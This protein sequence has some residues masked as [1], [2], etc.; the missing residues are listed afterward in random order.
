[1]KYIT[2]LFALLFIVSLTSCNQKET[3][4]ETNNLKL[5]YN[6]PATDWQSEALPIGNGFIGT[7]FFG[8]IEKEQIQFSEGTLW[9]GGLG[10]GDGYNYGIKK[11][12]WKNLAEVRKLLDEGKMKEAH[13]LANKELTGVNIKHENSSSNFGDYGAQQTMGDLFVAIHHQGEVENYIRELDIEKAEGRVSYTI[14]EHKYSRTYFGNY[15][16]KVMVYNF[17]STATTDY[18]VSFK[19]PHKTNNVSFEDAMYTYQGEVADNGMEFETKFKIETD[20]NVNYKNQLLEVTKATYLNVYHTAATEYV[21]QFPTYT[22][23]DYQAANNK[24]F[25][26]INGKSFEDL[27]K[28]HQD[29][30]TSLFNRVQL[31]LGDSKRDSIPT[32]VRLIEYSKGI[33]DLDFEELYFQYSRYLMIASSRPGGMPMHLQGKWNNSTNP[34][35]AA[36]YHMNINQQML[37][38]PAEVAN[39]SEL[40]LP[41]FDYMET[42]VAPGKITAK[43][44][45]NTR[46]WVVNTM[47]NPFGYTSPGWKFPWGFFPGGAAWLSQHLWE[48]YDFTQD[49]QFLKQTA[50][51]IM[52]GAA[53]FWMDYLI[54]DENGYLVSSPSYSPEHGGISRGASMDHQIAWDILNNTIEASKVLGVDK[55][56]ATKAQQIQDKIFPPTIGSWGQLQEWKEDVD[57]PESTHRHVSHLYAL[58]PGKQISIENTPELAAATK[59][60]LNARGDAGTGWSLAWKVNFW[61]RLKDGERAYKLYRRLLYPAATKGER[62]MGQGSGTFPNLFCAHPPFQLDGNMGGIAGMAEL[63]LQSHSGAIEF[64]PSLP[65]AW[66][67]GS[68]KGL[69]ARGGYEVNLEWKD[70][71]LHKAVI[72][73]NKKGICKVQ[74]KDSKKSKELSKGEYWEIQF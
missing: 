55:E 57:D 73:A 65:S 36:D 38:W 3:Q 29:D 49:E 53:L 30:Y 40:H 54:E 68:V 48:H 20:G 50:Y 58:H 9:S 74:Y 63:L 18:T 32:D 12:A 21:N 34:P 10:T 26:R 47:N 1:M 15:P 4:A 5:W 22:R 51:P 64:L 13:E 60:S 72:I 28:E 23:N 41:L 46:G 44:F 14:G 43:E 7:M 37:Y 71:V 31:E 2:K 52:K 67:N 8:G 33:T 25:E 70:G 62:L 61:A 66:K 35:W 56:F 16:S 11:G 42:L 6:Q 69:K 27:R 59:V 24:V 45:F 17:K 19:S 39:L